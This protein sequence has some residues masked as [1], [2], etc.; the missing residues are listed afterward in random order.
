M[1][2]IIGELGKSHKFVDL[3]H[4]IE[5][6]KSPI[7]ISGLTDVGM[8]QI[9]SGIHEF[10][11]KNVC[12]VTYNEIQ[13]RKIVEDIK[14]FTERVVF[15]P[16]KD[17]VAY[18]YIA[19]SK[20]LPYERIET[21][22]QIVSKK[23]FIVVTTIEA[24]M[25]S[26]IPKETLYKNPDWVLHG[27]IG[28]VFPQG[29]NILVCSEPQIGTWFEIN[30]SIA[31]KSEI[32]KDVFTLAFNHG[33]KPYQAN[34][35]YLV[36]PNKRTKKELRKYLKKENITIAANDTDMQVVKHNSLDICLMV[37]YK[38]GMFQD[39]SLCIEVSRP[40]AVLLKK[41]RKGRYRL[42]VADPGQ[43]GKNIE[44]KISTKKRSWQITFIPD[45]DPY[46]GATK[47][48]TLE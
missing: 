14:N 27:G 39:R 37:F 11:K 26:M 46:A 22:N 42:H 38:S 12:I 5:N 32:K 20:D 45:K 34:Y 48:F 43:T 3:I 41:E 47:A 40:C 33:E 21:L 36:V 7:A 16:K 29:G 30:N 35:A 4:E 6:K 15:F 13:A 17:I 44:L 1:N 8:T 19:E 24:I 2:T 31:N 10:A 28:Y 18:D 23:K 9:I 25:Q